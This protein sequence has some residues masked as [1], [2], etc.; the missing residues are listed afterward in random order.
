MNIDTKILSK[1]LA[2]Q[3]H[4]TL[5][6]IHHGQEG[7]FVGMQ[8]FFNICKSISVIHYIN[9]LKN[10]NYMIKRYRESL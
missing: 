8:P 7:F 10:K 6:I 2:N 3:I 9:K 1:M 4:N 5:K